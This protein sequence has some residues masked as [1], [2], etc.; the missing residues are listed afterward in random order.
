[1]RYFGPLSFDESKSERNRLQRRLPFEFVAEFDWT[2]ALIDMDDRRD[3][4][5]ERQL[6][7]GFIGERLYALIFVRRGPRIHVISF[8]KANVREQKKYAPAK[9]RS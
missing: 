3:Y 7:L 8:R 2:T 9:A 4:G 1:M 5:E 6:A